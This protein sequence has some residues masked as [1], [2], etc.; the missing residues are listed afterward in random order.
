MIGI[1]GLAIWAILCISVLVAEVR[2]G[3]RIQ[4]DRFFNSSGW[5]SKTYVYLLGWQYS[6]IAS[7]VVSP[8]STIRSSSQADL[9]G[10]LCS[11]SLLID[12]LHARVDGNADIV[13]WRKR[14]R[15]H[16]EMSRKL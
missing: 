12:E 3:G 7:G 2:K 16:R 9:T 14:P 5:D 4:T 11:V 10:C 15:T 13:V 8:P 6:T 1:Y